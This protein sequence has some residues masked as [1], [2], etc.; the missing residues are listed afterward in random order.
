MSEL[1][2]VY[3]KN[4]NDNIYYGTD[5]FSKNTYNI[6]NRLY[7]IHKISEKIDNFQ[8]IEGRVLRYE[9]HVHNIAHFIYDTFLT[10]FHYILNNSDKF[11]KIFI[12]IKSDYKDGKLFF[13]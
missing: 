10:F 6:K 12:N 2:D 8:I 11:D 9:L 13:C 4:R 1:N 3:L 7:N 5:L